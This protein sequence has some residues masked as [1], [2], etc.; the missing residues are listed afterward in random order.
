MGLLVMEDGGSYIYIY[1]FTRLKAFEDSLTFAF[2]TRLSQVRHPHVLP[3]PTFW[4]PGPRTDRWWE[5]VCDA[6]P[7]VKEIQ[8]EGC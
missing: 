3:L 1:R 8:Q 7:W 5:H 4:A 6:V 2:G